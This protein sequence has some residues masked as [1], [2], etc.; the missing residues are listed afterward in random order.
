M[1]HGRRRPLWDTLFGGGYRQEV[2]NTM[3]QWTFLIHASA[4][5]HGRWSLDAH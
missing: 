4:M 2:F 3:A 1:Y 5:G